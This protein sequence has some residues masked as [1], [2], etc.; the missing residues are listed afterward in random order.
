LESRSTWPAFLRGETTPASEVETRYG[1]A[2]QEAWDRLTNLDLERIARNSLSSL[3]DA[4]VEVRFLGAIY[5]VRPTERRVETEGEDADPF[6]SILILHYLLGCGSDHPTGNLITFWEI[7]GGDIYHSSFRRRAI[8]TLAKAIGS[9]AERLLKVG[10]RLGAS[11]QIIGDA[12]VRIDAF[13]KLPV[14]VVFWEGDQEIPGSA[15][16]LFDETA[17]R[18]LAMED[19]SVVGNLVSFRLRKAL[20]NLPPDETSPEVSGRG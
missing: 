2:L 13:P 6:T 19:L 10:K 20:E 18:L 12:S 14:T 17:P 16:I 4:G 15:N 3:M 11:I 7:P 1:S 8:D 9:S 5:L